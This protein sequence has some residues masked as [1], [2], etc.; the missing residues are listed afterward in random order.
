MPPVRWQR[1]RGR[2]LRVRVNVLVTVLALAVLVLAWA[3]TSTL[4]AGDRAAF[5]AVSAMWVGMPVFFLWLDYF[6]REDK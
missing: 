4:D 2:E 6:N 3:A 5:I 1:Y